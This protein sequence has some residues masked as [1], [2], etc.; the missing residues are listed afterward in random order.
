ML[1]L[2]AILLAALF[3]LF[4]LLFHHL[5]YYYYHCRTDICFLIFSLSECLDVIAAAVKV[6]VVP[7]STLKVT[8]AVSDLGSLYQAVNSLS[9]LSLS[10]TDNDS[11]S[12]KGGEKSS[13]KSGDKGSEKGSG[14]SKKS[15]A[16]SSADKISSNDSLINDKFSTTNETVNDKESNNNG[17][18][19]FS[20]TDDYIVRLSEVYND[21]ATSVI[22]RIKM[23]TEFVDF[24]TKKVID[25]CRGN[26]EVEKEVE[27]KVDNEVENDSPIVVDFFEKELE[28]DEDY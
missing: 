1:I 9:G 25:S 2:S 24:F 3:L 12:S 5:Y 23:P 28:S 18:Y 14:R 4:S 27:E 26:A 19:N 22:L 7:A 20:N 10:I 21:D 16:N 15:A 17:N 13:E 6:P 11:N 8:A